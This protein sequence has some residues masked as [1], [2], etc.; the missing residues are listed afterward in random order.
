MVVLLQRGP[1]PSPLPLTQ[2]RGLMGERSFLTPSP[3]S[4]ERVGVRAALKL[5]PGSCPSGQGYDLFFFSLGLAVH[6][7]IQSGRVGERRF[8]GELDRLGH[9]LLGL[10]V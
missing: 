8:V 3:T 1:H 7:V 4:W 9:F 10:L 6:V 5:C 2:E